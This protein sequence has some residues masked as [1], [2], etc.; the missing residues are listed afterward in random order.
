[1]AKII[2]LTMSVVVSCGQSNAMPGYNVIYI[3]KEALMMDA[4][5]REISKAASRMLDNNGTPLYDL[6]K[7]YNSDSFIVEG[8]IGDALR[9]VVARFP[10]VSLLQKT[11]DGYTLSFYLPDIDP[12]MGAA[13]RE[14]LNRL[15]SMQVASSWMATRNETFAKFYAEQA[16]ASMERLVVLL[17]TRKTPER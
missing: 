11:D 15:V 14:E 17:R 3:V 2:A 12:S 8:F 5:R 4:A 10:D 7:V 13:G 16:S 9:Q 1:M 6:I